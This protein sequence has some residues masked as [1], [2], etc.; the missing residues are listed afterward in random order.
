MPGEREK[1]GRMD[2]RDMRPDFADALIAH[3][4]GVAAC[5]EP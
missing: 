3:G 2:F 1:S 4:V 5:G